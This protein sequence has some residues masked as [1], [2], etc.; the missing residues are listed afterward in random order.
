MVV[1]LT[2]WGVHDLLMSLLFTGFLSESFTGIM[3]NTI[4][5][6]ER[7]VLAQDPRWGLVERIVA[8]PS[9]IKSDRLCSFLIYICE[10]SLTGRKDEI[11]EIN[12]GARLFG[13]PDYDPS[14]DGIVRSHASRMRQRLEQYFSQEGADEPIR[15]T[16]PKGA[17]IP[18]FELRPYTLVAPEG[19][20]L[21]GE[22]LPMSPEPVTVN[23]EGHTHDTKGRWTVRILATALGLACLVILYMLP[24]THRAAVTS[25]PGPDSHP[26]WR[27]FFGSGH[28]TLVVCSDTSLATLQDVTGQKVG[29]SDYLNA[30][31]RMRFAPPQGTTMEVARDIGGRRYTAIADVGIL[32]RFY[33]LA[34]AHADRI[35]YR[36]ARDV[37]PDDLKEG[38]TILIGSAYSDPWVGIFDAHMNFVFQDD[39]KHRVFAVV[40]R[41]PQPGELAQYDY[42]QLD[43]AHKI[44]GVVGLR[45]NL[46]GSGKVL[47][48]EG[49]SMAGT[50]AAAD[51]V[52]DDTLLLPFLSKIRNP[53]GSIP[54]FEVLLQ[55]SNMNGSASQLKVIAYRTSQD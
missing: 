51:F 10:L 38:S 3:V 26:F 33:R 39:L 15:L 45:P 8:S 16:I 11:N 46:R 20:L 17:Y 36:Y 25:P 6:T 41:S 40:N 30:N 7:E 35:Q 50:E 9:F 37:R 31:Y 21:E 19:L 47:I 23:Q 18:V 54:Y 2:H 4:A 14:I 12:I 13:R 53:D 42:N 22:V 24:L 27:L 49:T 55:S 48:L 28:H 43:A 5:Q 44:Y 34:G 29:L 32:T 1:S 52:F